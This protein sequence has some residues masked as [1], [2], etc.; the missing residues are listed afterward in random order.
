MP[1][2]IPEIK[3][4]CPNR[5]RIVARLIS[6][7]PLAVPKVFNTPRN[8]TPEASA[9]MPK[10]SFTETKSQ[11]TSSNWLASQ[12]VQRDGPRKRR[13]I[14]HHTVSNSAA[15]E[16]SSFP[17]G[18]G[19]RNIAEDEEVEFKSDETRNGESIAQLR[20]MVMG[21]LELTKIQQQYVALAVYH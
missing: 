7:K 21:K 11:P 2:R 10:S 6:T 17:R 16:P 3:R 8:R 4:L 5:V 9:C 19:S 12:K 20:K 14:D 13:K 18:N 15:A 1:V